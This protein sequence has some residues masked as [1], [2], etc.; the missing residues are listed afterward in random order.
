MEF[1]LISD[2]KIKVM[3][4]EEDLRE[5]EIEADE[6]DYANTDTKRMF[7]DILSRAKHIT[8]FDTDGQ[9]VLVQIYPSRHGGCEMFVTKIG[10]LCP[11]EEGCHIQGKP[12]PI[13]SEKFTVKSRGRSAAREKKRVCVFAFETL[14]QMLSVCRRLFSLGY[15]EE[16]SAYIGENRR[17]YLLLEGIDTTGYEPIDKFSFI[18]E[19]GV[20]E[21]SDATD[22]FLSERGMSI[23]SQ[24]A[25]ETLSRC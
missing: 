5:F 1:I 15:S 17:C 11:S 22:F 21:N 19:F 20:L 25:V 7:W 9:K 14:E 16:S 6:L 12:N 2:S 4:T 18:Y 24:K 13:I 8:G 3:L 23:C 10:S